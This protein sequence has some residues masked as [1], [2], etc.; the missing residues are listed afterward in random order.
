MMPLAMILRGRGARGRRA[1]TARSTQGRVPAK[2]DALRALGIALFP[3]DGS[4]VAS[5]EQI[6]VASAAV[7]ETR[8]R[9]RRRATALG[10]ARLTRAELLAELFNA[11]AHARS[12]WPGPAASRP[13]PA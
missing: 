2:F 13:S 7:E 3:Q 5:A 9:H 11:A 4:G 8:A 12:A 6:V 1:P 10:C